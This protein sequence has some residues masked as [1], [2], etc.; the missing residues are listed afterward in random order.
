M[1]RA[2][3]AW[4]Q[5]RD[6]RLA[7]VFTAADERIAKTYFQHEIQIVGAMHRAGVGVLAGTDVSN[8]WVYWGSS[9][10]DELAMFVDAG[11]TPMAALQAATIEPARFLHA[12]DTLGTVEPGKVG[13]PGDPRRRS[14]CRHPQHPA[15]LRHRRTRTFRRQRR[16]SATINRREKRGAEHVTGTTRC[17][18]GGP[19]VNR[20]PKRAP[21]SRSHWRVRARACSSAFPRTARGVD[22]ISRASAR[23]VRQIAGAETSVLAGSE[24]SNG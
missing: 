14:P 19:H 5:A 10:H 24:G 7:S 4:W 2:D 11:F 13:G 17:R 9:L 18:P 8:P 6:R 22:G 20:A 3:T 16:P 1:A 21:H 15:H 12:T 23:V